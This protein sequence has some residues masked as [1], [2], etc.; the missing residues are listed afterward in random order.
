M[1][2]A[3]GENGHTPTA[4]SSAPKQRSDVAAAGDVL[5]GAA[6]GVAQ[7]Q[8]YSFPLVMV[9]LALIFDQA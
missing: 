1:L 7:P 6:E 4:A 5:H 3:H 8:Q 2:A 9:W